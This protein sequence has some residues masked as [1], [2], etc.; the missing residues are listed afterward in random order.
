MTSCGGGGRCWDLR[1]S[2]VAGYAPVAKRK[3]SSAMA[4]RAR[5]TEPCAWAK[6]RAELLR[7]GRSHLSAILYG[8]TCWISLSVAALAAF[9]R[10]GEMVWWLVS[11]MGR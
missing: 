1:S 8:V 11:A 2:R 10:A 5:L 4:V 3:R 9:V 6:R 7:P